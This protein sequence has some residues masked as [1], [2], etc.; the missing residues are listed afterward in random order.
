MNRGLLVG[1]IAALVLGIGAYGLSPLWAV[2]NLQSAAQ[3]GDRDEF[4]QAV[5][6]PAIR[7]SLKG[8]I[9]ALLV[10]SMRSDPELKDNPFAAM[11]ALLAPALTDRMVD[12]VVTPEG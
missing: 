5:D 9:A 4:E 6:F 3:S 1:L 11:G 2:H 7:E 12:S 8:Q 10:R